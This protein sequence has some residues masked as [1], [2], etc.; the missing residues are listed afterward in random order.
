M[1]IFENFP[2]TNFHELNLDWL[3]N[4]VKRQG[5]EIDKMMDLFPFNDFYTVN[6]KT[7]SKGSGNCDK[8]LD[9]IKAAIISGKRI[10]FNW[11]EIGG[12]NGDPMLF[13]AI[14]HANAIAATTQIN[15]AWSIIYDASIGSTI[16]LKRRIYTMSIDV[17]GPVFDWV[18]DTIS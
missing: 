6:V 11:S 15:F 13:P 3:L 2:Y 7:G 10:R 9:D 18:E 1:G 4:V 5:R 14:T 12:E 8:T 17:N 16:T